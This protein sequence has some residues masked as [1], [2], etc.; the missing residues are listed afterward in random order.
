MSNLI[1]KNKVKRKSINKNTVRKGNKEYYK[2]TPKGI[3]KNNAHIPKKVILFISIFVLIMLSININQNRY[4]K[5]LENNQYYQG[6]KIKIKD[7]QKNLP[8]LKKQL[9]IHDV[10]YKWNKEL[11]YNNKPKL[12]VFHHTASKQLTPQQIHDMHINKEWAGIGYHFYIKKDGTIYRGRPEDAIGA[13]I[14]GKN[15]DSLGICLEGNLEEENPTEDEIKS[16][17]KLSTYLI[18]KYNINKVQ[19]HGDT[20]D[21]LCPGKNFPMELVKEEITKDIKEISINVN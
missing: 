15:K 2:I 1:S 3:H 4:V 17:E 9:G 5:F 10:Q 11:E 12:L 21:T 20:Y 14:K 16:L 18:V 8:N 6:S 13:H 19:G 7:L